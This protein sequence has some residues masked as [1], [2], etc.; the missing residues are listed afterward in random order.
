MVLP[1]GTCADY[2]IPAVKVQKYTID[3][4]L[5]RKLLF[6]IPFYIL[7]YEKELSQIN[8]SEE[9]LNRLLQ[10]Y[11]RIYKYLHELEMGRQISEGCGYN[12]TELTQRI[13]GVVADKA[14]NVKREV[15][16]MCGK[17]LELES[18]RLIKTALEQGLEQG[19]IRT[20][21]KNILGIMNKLGLTFEEACDIC[22]VPKEK[23]EVYREMI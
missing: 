3:D 6:F 16:T 5:D 12:L 13:V 8:E 14:G 21:V 1:D 18:E 20:T 23:Y 17:V 7:R 10:D 2:R 4:I 15:N 11:R 9:R 22:D 19:T